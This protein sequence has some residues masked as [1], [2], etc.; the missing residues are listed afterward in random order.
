MVTYV[1]STYHSNTTIFNTQHKKEPKW[2]KPQ[3]NFKTRPPQLLYFDGNALKEILRHVAAPPK[4]Q[5]QHHRVTEEEEDLILLT[6][7]K[8]GSTSAVA[9]GEKER[10]SFPLQAPPDKVGEYTI[11]PTIHAGY[12]ATWFGLSG[13]GL[14]MTRKLLTRGRA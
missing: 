8:Q 9:T 3:H 6:Q 13:A 11:S 10:L 2:I 14:I 4:E 12:A 1:Q 7:I 5:S